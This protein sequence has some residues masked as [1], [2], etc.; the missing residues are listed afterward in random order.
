MNIALNSR[1]FKS[2]PGL[3]ILKLPHTEVSIGDSLTSLISEILTPKNNAIKDLNTK[4]NQVEVQD[5]KK[6]VKGVLN[7]ALIISRADIKCRV[8]F[9]SL[10]ILNNMNENNVM[11][12]IDMKKEIKHDNENSGE[13]IIQ[14]IIK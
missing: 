7:A 13:N 6:D 12:K 8:H 2:L 9:V 11:G 3:S 14:Y 1:L 5:D 10:C 4:N